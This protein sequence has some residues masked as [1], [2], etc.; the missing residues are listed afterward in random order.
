MYVVICYTLGW[1]NI[2]TIYGPFWSSNEAYKFSRDH[3]RSRVMPVTG[4]DQ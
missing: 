3:D 1:E 2:H 4:T